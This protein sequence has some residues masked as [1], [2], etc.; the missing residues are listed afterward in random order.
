MTAMTALCCRVFGHNYRVSRTGS[1]AVNGMPIFR[2]ETCSRELL[3]PI[4]LAGG[5]LLKIGQPTRRDRFR[6][7]GAYELGPRFTVAA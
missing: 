3:L 6:S 5:V 2:C 4:P 1:I 7:D